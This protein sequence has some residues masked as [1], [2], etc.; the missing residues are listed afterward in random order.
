LYR[1][2]RRDKFNVPIGSYSYI[3]YKREFGLHQ[4]VLLNANCEFMT[5]DFADVTLRSD[6]FVYADP[7]YDQTFDQ[8][9]AA[10]FSWDDQQ[11][12]AYWL[13]QH[14]GPVVASNLATPRIIALYEHLGFTLTYLNAPRKI[15]C[16]GNRT[17]AREML[18]TRNL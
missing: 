3:D 13:A 11:R 18:A 8:Y 10:R 14:S 12:L 16:N 9:T 6:D 15:S 1:V 7:P 5:G 2:N 4:R 17:P